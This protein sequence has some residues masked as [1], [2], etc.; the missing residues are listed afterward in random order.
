MYQYQFSILK[1]CWLALCV[2]FLCTSYA[3]INTGP[4][5]NESN[6]TANVD[7]NLLFEQCFTAGLNTANI[8]DLDK[9]KAEF[10]IGL[11]ELANKEDFSSLKSI[12]TINTYLAKNY[13]SKIVYDA[14]PQ[15]ALLGGRFNN[16]SAVMLQGLALQYLNVN[17]IINDTKTGIR[18]SVVF[19]ADTLLLS[20]DV[21][22][23]TDNNIIRQFDHFKT[24]LFRNGRI[25]KTDANDDSFIDEHF[26]TDTILQIYQLP[27]LQYF[28]D[29][30]Q[31][32]KS[33]QYSNALKQLEKA[34]QLY[35]VPYIEQWMK[36][37]LGIALSDE[38]TN[39]DP[40][41]ECDFLL[42]F[43]DVNWDV[44]DIQTQITNVATTQAQQLAD[45]PQKVE[46]FLRCIENGIDNE[47]LKNTLTEKIYLVLA[48]S[49][50]GNAQYQNAI[51]N[52]KKLYVSDSTMH[53]NYIKNSVIQSLYS[54]NEDSIRVDSLLNYEKKFS[55]LKD[56]AELVKYKT[57]LLTNCIYDNFENKKETTG[58][59]YLNKF[60]TAFPNNDDKTLNTQ[61]ISSAYASASQYFINIQNFEMAD[62]LINE[63]KIYC[64]EN[65]TFNKL[66]QTIKTNKK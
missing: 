57:Y 17:V 33:E 22:A 21:A 65:E 58:L 5:I 26:L 30:V 43:S 11:D 47:D 64:G 44:D 2:T 4:L 41:A 56:D 15:D 8:F 23:L 50:Y 60:R 34:H 38:K 12:N 37:V 28:N 6:A 55:F 51:N 53:H 25:S 1:F 45:Q 46:S 16:T 19:N 27:A 3:Q 7:Y 54:L 52:F 24:M 61:Q 32:F 31:L 29:G 10:F 63:G 18:T 48:E 66:L 49:Y 62:N 9:H 59:N 42:K 39:D 40:T 14:I 35:A 20:E 36:L 13:F